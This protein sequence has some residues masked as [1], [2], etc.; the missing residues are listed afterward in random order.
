[1]SENKNVHAEILKTKIEDRQ[2]EVLDEIEERLK[3]VPL[4]ITGKERG[5]AMVN[6][7]EKIADEKVYAKSKEILER[8]ATEISENDMHELD[9]IHKEEM[10][11]LLSRLSLALQLGDNDIA[12]LDHALGL[13]RATEV[14]QAG[15]VSVD[16]LNIL[17][18]L[19]NG[20][21][22]DLESEDGK[23]LVGL[24]RKLATLGKVDVRQAVAE[25]N[26]YAGFV[27]LS[28]LDSKQ[29]VDLLKEMKNDDAYIPLLMKLVAAN[30]LTIS[31]GLDLLEIAKNKKDIEAAR[32]DMDSHG[33][34]MYQQD[35]MKIQ[36]K[37]NDIYET[38][39]SQN[40]AGKYLNPQTYL[41]VKAGQTLGIMTMAANFFANVTITNLWKDPGK[42][43]E[44]VGSLGTNPAFLLG[45]GATG[46]TFEYVTG[47][48]GKGWI[49]QT[50]DKI[51]S[52]SSISP[53][54]AEKIKIK[55]MQTIFGNYPDVTKFYFDHCEKIN[56]LKAQHKEITLKSI[57][58]DP[59]E[60]KGTNKKELEDNLPQ[61]LAILTDKE[62]GFGLEG[63]SI[64]SSVEL[65]RD[66]INQSRRDQGLDTF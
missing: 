27:I 2:A 41:V 33:M 10:E 49:S 25:T 53:E 18:K 17:Q 48:I 56:E 43:A 15:K 11:A 47:G 65:Q 54:D 4:S 28:N 60:S 36:L 6:E 20:E 59:N 42:F 9:K 52:D 62:K 35:V 39:F 51:T 63:S 14:E 55:Q 30:Y 44:Q 38:N 24:M 64:G 12:K 50:F 1:M 26:K 58:I 5:E 13:F 16:Y 3:D 22:I 66:F 37:A 34:R 61:F 19:K 31:Q 45:L 57:G 7:L 40:Y 21:D 29:R 8:Q 46:L 32:A 23:H